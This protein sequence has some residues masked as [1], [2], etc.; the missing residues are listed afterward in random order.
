MLVVMLRTLLPMTIVTA[1]VSPKARPSPMKLAP[2]MPERDRGSTAILSISQRVA[3]SASAA[4][5]SA[6]GADAGDRPQRVGDEVRKRVRGGNEG[7]NPPEP[8][9]HAG[10]GGEEIDEVGQGLADAPRRDI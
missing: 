1:I 8:V 4:S 9:D 2:T 3:P 5:L 7:E 6:F 10:D